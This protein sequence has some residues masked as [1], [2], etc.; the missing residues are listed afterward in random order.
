MTTT[1]QQPTTL[2]LAPTAFLKLYA[3]KKFAYLLALLTFVSM[4]I[5]IPILIY[6]A[7]IHQDTNTGIYMAFYSAGIFV[8]FTIP[9]S[10]YEIFLHLTHWYMPDVQKYVVRVLWMVPIYSL[11]SW[12]SL[13]FHNASVLL[14]TIRGVYEA[15]VICSFVY[16]LI[17]LMGGEASMAET[18]RKKNARYGQHS[19]RILVHLG[20]CKDWSM[21]EEFLIKIKHGVL[22]YVVLKTLLTVVTVILEATGLYREDSL[23][24]GIDWKSGYF[25]VAIFLNFSISYALYCLV[26]LFYA[27]KGDLTS[28]VNWHPAG[29][30]ICIKVSHVGVCICLYYCL[31]IWQFYDVPHCHFYLFVCSFAR[32]RALCS[33]PFGKEYSYTYCKPTA[34][35]TRSGIRTPPLYQGAFKT[36]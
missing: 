19:P 33:S 26:K 34:S 36:T 4:V 29:K 14:D 21:G 1:F 20:V 5:G 31:S 13:R 22:Q 23:V 18:L 7:F 2:I 10:T 32:L 24:K 28:P 27:I 15:Y 9:I 3:R 30:F 17:G 8:I 11:Q 16:Y 35:S 12:L 25:Y 6:F